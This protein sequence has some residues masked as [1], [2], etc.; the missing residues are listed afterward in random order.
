[1]KSFEAPTIYAI[2]YI[3]NREVK[4]LTFTPQIKKSKVMNPDSLTLELLD[5][6][7]IFPHI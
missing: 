7:I 5:L 1:M 3:A 4:S 2:L 6:T